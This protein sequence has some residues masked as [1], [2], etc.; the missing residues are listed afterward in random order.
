MI[1]ALVCGGGGF[2]GGHIVNSLRHCNVKS[3]R[4]V[5]I[6]PFHKWYQIFRDVENLVLD[7]READNCYKV[8]NDCR[9]I[10][11]LAILDCYLKSFASTKF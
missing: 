4:V 5:D 1:E 8:V 9:V 2:I 11:N 10:Y 3:I 6:K 7:L